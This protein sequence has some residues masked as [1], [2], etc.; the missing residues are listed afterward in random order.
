[1]KILDYFNKIY[2]ITQPGNVSWSH[3]V[4]NRKKLHGFL[5]N[6]AAMIIESDIRISANGVA[7]AAH[8]P[9]TES[10]LTFDELIL[11]IQISNQGL[12]LDFKDP[13]ILIG[14]LEKIR[15]AKLLKPILLNADIL[16]GN[17]ANPSKFSAVGF[18]A[19]CKKY[20]PA[21]I[22]SVGWTTTTEHD[23]TKQNVDAMLAL[24][25]N[26][27]ELTFPVRACLL[28]NSWSE[29]QR[30]LDRP[31]RTLTV[32]NNETVDAKLATWIKTNTDP[33]KTFY[34]FIDPVSKDPIKLW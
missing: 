18:L 30:L 1:M 31:G 12:K 25:G 14:C 28:P 20:Y 15:D 6:P 8:P 17:G 10:D 3:A 22:L 32:W 4:N 13:E 23:Y 5:N 34:D 19:L 29:L 16:Q 9:E 26:I 7:V 33:A 27:D 21:G 24:V 11:M 2:G